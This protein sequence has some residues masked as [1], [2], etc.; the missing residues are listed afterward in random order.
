MDRLRDLRGRPS[1]ARTAAL[2][3]LAGVGAGCSESGPTSSVTVRDSSGVTIV[4]STAP[5][6]SDGEG[7]TLDSTPVLDLTLTGAGE[8][9]EFYGVSDGTLLSDGSIVISERRSGQIK[10][11][12]PAG[13]FLGAFGS[14]GEGPGEFSWIRAI[15]RMPG[16]TV[17]AFDQRNRRLTKIG[18]DREMAGIG[19]LPL[20]F[21]YGAHPLA[22]DT[23]LLQVGAPDQ[24]EPSDPGHLRMPIYVVRAFFA[25]EVIDTVA[26]GAGS[27][28]VSLDGGT[29][30]A[31]PFFGK[32]TYVTVHAGRFYL[33]DS[34][35]LEVRTFAFDGTLE[36]AIRVSGFDLGVEDGSIDA[37]AALRVE[38]NPRNRQINEMLPRPSHKPAYA[39]IIVDSEGYVW[40]GEHRGRFRNM[41]GDGPQE[42]QVFSP[43]GAWLGSLDLPGRFQVY[44]IGRDY[45]LGLR[46]DA[47]DLERPQLLRLNR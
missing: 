24:S 36:R 7:F 34:D 31:A 23:V 8:A 10:Y 37:E 12:S 17:L 16:D 6:W 44:E 11:Y 46:R 27:E 26:R 39:S 13:E 2:V 15:H 3:C 21:V 45:I 40:T 18:P 4:E 43:D 38:I 1:A 5:A 42:W 41:L 35:S 22:A 19:P 14:R 30:D 47:I 32:N 28:S 9:Y 25:G 33:G 20:Q 29:I